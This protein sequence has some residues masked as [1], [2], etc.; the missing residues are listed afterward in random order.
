MIQQLSKY[1][2]HHFKHVL[3][4]DF[5]KALILMVSEISPIILKHN[6]DLKNVEKGSLYFGIATYGSLSVAFNVPEH[7]KKLKQHHCF[8]GLHL[9]L[10][11][12]I[13]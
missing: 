2:L 11:M 5:I 6:I 10:C 1:F 4:L 12:Q 7:E 8:Y 13:V 9:W 3:N